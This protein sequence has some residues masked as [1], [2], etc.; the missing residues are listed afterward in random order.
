[1][2]FCPKCKKVAEIDQYGFIFCTRCNKYFVIKKRKGAKKKH[3]K[4]QRA[5]YQRS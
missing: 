5:F 2:T 4:Y 1:M 3:E